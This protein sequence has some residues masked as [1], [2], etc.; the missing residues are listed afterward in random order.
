MTRNSGW[1]TL[2]VLAVLA[3]SVAENADA[4][5]TLET[6]TF[7]NGANG[8]DGAFDRRIDMRLIDE[9]EGTFADASEDGAS[10]D[11]DVDPFFIDGDP[12]DSSRSDYLIRFDDILGDMGIPSGAII[13]DATLNLRTT[14]ES[15]NA[16]SRTGESYNVYR[17]AVP[18]DS[19]STMD[20]TFGDGNDMFTDNVDG[21]EPEQGEADWI[22]ST[23]DHPVDEGGLEPDMTYG[24][25][26]TRAVQSWVDGA[27][28]YGLAV[29]SDHRDNDDGWSVH[30]TGSSTVS[31]RPE[32][33]VT[34]TISPL[35]R[36]NEF[37]Q[38][39]NGYTGTTD[40]L[41]NLVTD[42]ASTDERDDDTVVGGLDASTES[43][44]FLDGSNATP[45]EPNVGNS[46]DTPYLIKF[47]DVESLGDNGR[48]VY[49]AELLVTTG[50][51]S[52]VSDS[53]GPFTVHQLLTPFDTTSVYGDYSGDVNDMLAANEIAP[54]AA[55]FES[56]D[57]GEYVAVDVT[58]VVDNWF[59]GDPNYGFYI[60][61]NGTSNG[62][63]IFTSGA[64]DSDLAPMLRIYTVPEPASVMLGA[65]GLLAL[66]V[67]RRRPNAC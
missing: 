39:L 57:E 60:G 11:T 8:Y 48:R 13:L 32:L 38:G 47:D 54:E 16:N 9:N 5:I 42:T 53:G 29:M 64:I 1:L 14:S 41:L 37:Q 25:S 26:V 52:G 20:G 50:F 45:E 10:V 61:A 43:E 2:S 56:I 35:M 63:Q 23:F 49:K 30:S 58:S 22:L 17:L 62:W 19:T 59:S 6:L 67:Y 21:V 15:V 33:S 4:Q 7:Q 65:F 55:R 36:V 51:S 12:V 40:V 3:T 44:V 27:T 18:F 46:Y 24:A 31:S 28:N 34:Y 66:A